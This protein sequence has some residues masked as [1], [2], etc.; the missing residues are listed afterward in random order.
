MKS[1][2]LR[3]ELKKRITK[4]QQDIDKLKE[5]RDEMEDQI[6]EAEERLITWR[7]AYEMESKRLGKPVLPFSTKT[8]KSYRFAGMKLT[9]ALAIVQ[10]EHPEI[11]KEQPKIGKRAALKVLQD[12][13]FDFRGKR[14][15]P[16]V[17]FAWVA[18]GRR[19]K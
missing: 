19:K 7:E 18:L 6:D 3:G 14:P 12:E 2:D 4:A 1:V 9:K 8:G 5:K 13:G 16:A 11:S 17:H 10:K 15:L